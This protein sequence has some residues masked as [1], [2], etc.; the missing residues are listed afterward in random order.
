MSKE[1]WLPVKGYEGIYE[2]SNKGR[3][4]SLPRMVDN[5]T[6][7]TLFKGGIRKESLDSYGYVKYNMSK[8]S[9]TKG[10]LA[11]RIVAL[12][13]IPNPEKR[14]QINHINA[15]KTDNRVENLEWCTPM[16][17]I[18]HSME[19]GLQKKRSGEEIHFAILTEKE[20][21]EIRSKYKPRKYTFKRLGIEY[22]VSYQ[23]I[24]CI[25]HKRSWKHI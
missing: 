8:D 20:V 7:K 15:V 11:H 23:T 6:K 16:E 17:N 12:A 4:K 19:M 3:L 1:V 5:Y 21:I 14:P 18:H 10:M 22:G 24:Q 25:I 13:F 9:V 2:I